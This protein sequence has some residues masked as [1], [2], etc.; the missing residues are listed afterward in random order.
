MSHAIA[1]LLD[2]PIQNP[3]WV[4]VI[5]MACFFGATAL[6]IAWG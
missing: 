5:A 6:I 2:R 3:L 1:S 4:I